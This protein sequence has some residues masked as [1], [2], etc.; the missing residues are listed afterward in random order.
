MFGSTPLQPN[1]HPPPEP[2]HA[3]G[4]HHESQSIR[5]RRHTRDRSRVEA[6]LAVARPASLIATP[7]QQRFAPRRGA[8]DRPAWPA[9]GSR[10]A[11]RVAE[12]IPPAELRGTGVSPGRFRIVSRLRAA[13]D[14][15]DAEEGGA[16]E[17]HQRGPRGPLGSDTS[18][19][20]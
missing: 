4:T 17:D 16:A 1:P 20:G 10:V 12:A 8:R 18:G 5:Y 13:A 14:G 6:D 15:L 7:G 9:G 2:D 11:Q 19:G 3:S